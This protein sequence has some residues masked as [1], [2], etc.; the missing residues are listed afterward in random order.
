MRVL[1]CNDDGVDAPGIARAA[2]AARTLADD[3]WIVAPEVKWTAA[4]HRVSFDRDLVLTRRAPRTWSCSGTPADCVVAAMSAIE[5]GL[6]PDLVVAGINDKRNV[7][8]DLAYSGT[9]AI[10]REATMRGVPA[11]ALSRDDWP[12]DASADEAEVG[13][14]LRLLWSERATWLAPGAWLSVNLPARLPAPLRQ[15]TL[16]RDKIASAADVTERT[17]ERIVFRLRRG[18]PGGA[19]EGDENALLALGAVVVVRHRWDAAA[20][21]PEALVGAW[22][23]TFASGAA[24][25]G[26]EAPGEST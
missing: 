1:V 18:R 16:A 15:A 19:R 17:H 9:L 11:I 20:P 24:P 2:A 8:E 5:G 12:A 25:P 10:A 22:S 14:L 23:A 21:L 26:L 13:T 7:G 4:S 6:A 3:V